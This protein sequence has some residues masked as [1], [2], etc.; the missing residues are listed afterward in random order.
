MATE[1]QKQDILKRYQ[2][3]VEKRDAARK[4]KRDASTA[5]KQATANVS[6]AITDIARIAVDASAAGVPL[7]R[8]KRAG[9]ANTT[10][11]TVN[12]HPDDADGDEAA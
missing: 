7:P 11:D 2:D 5:V 4:A 1:Q 10:S 8:G 9:A 3:A 12:V 6:E